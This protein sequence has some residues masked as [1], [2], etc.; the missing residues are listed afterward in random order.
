MNI[1]QGV[2]H[3]VPNNYSLKEGD[4]LSVDIGLKYQNFH[5]DMART[6]LV[7]N[8]NAKIT[9]PRQ[10]RDE[11]GKNQKDAFLK[12]GRKTLKKAIE[13]YKHH[14]PLFLRFLDLV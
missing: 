12:V 13:L 1:N 9:R 8:Q 3:G 5:T 6:I 11:V 14:F 4:L 10:S 2:V 7:R